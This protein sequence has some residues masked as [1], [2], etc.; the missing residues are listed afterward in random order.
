MSNRARNGVNAN[1]AVVVQVGPADFSPGPLGGVR[2]QQELER[3]AYLAGLPG[4]EGFAPA[5]RAEDFLKRRTGTLGDVWPTCRPG[6]QM[7]KPYLR[8]AGFC[9]EGRR[10]RYPC[11]RPP[12]CGVRSARRRTDSGGKP[13]QR[14][15]A[16]PAGTGTA[17]ANRRAWALS[18]GRGRGLCGW[19]RQRGCGRH[20]MPPNRSLP[21][22]SQGRAER[23]YMVLPEHT[24]FARKNI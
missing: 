23:L 1:A 7:A 9:G 17:R 8:A 20:G 15:R 10:G 2:F 12:A 18:R 3:R 24:G 16:H 13:H 4:G 5:Q 22:I 19:Y 11:V 14:P 6:V 21:A